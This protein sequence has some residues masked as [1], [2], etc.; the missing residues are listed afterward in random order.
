MTKERIILSSGALLI[1]NHNNI[2]IINGTTPPHVFITL[3]KISEKHNYNA[4]A[5]VAVRHF[6]LK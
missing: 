5:V 4:C 2:K 6:M 3:E 1:P